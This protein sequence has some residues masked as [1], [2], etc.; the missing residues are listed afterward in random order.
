M[1]S[2]EPCLPGPESP[3]RPHPGRR[4]LAYS[5]PTSRVKTCTLSRVCG[6][7]PSFWI[8]AR[9]R[10][11][12]E[13]GK[14][15]NPIANHYPGIRFGKFPENRPPEN[16]ALETAAESRSLESRLKF[17]NRDPGSSLTQL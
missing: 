1:E 7:M 16:I 5:R 12:L 11:R 13:L 9:T 2:G 3:I 8:V 17:D 4:S 14:A 10:P 6:P 15:V